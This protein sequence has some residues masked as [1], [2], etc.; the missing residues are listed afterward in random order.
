M[1]CKTCKMCKI[2]SYK[3]FPSYIF[4]KNYG[5]TC[6]IGSYKGFASLSIFRQRGGAALIKDLTFLTFPYMENVRRGAALI[7]DLTRITHLTCENSLPKPPSAP[8]EVIVG[9]RAQ[10]VGDTPN[11]GVSPAFR[12]TCKKQ[13]DYKIYHRVNRRHIHL[14]S[15]WHIRCPANNSDLQWKTK[16]FN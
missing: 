15:A 8:P 10:H 5:R 3:G 16:I 7:K 13:A 9:E 1:A 12:N 14:I 2:S 11:F 6:K 4:R